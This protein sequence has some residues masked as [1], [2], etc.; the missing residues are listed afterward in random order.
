MQVNVYGFL[1]VVGVFL[2]V[3]VNSELVCR[4]IGNWFTARS[5]GLRKAKEEYERLSGVDS[6]REQALAGGGR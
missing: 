2:T 4:E 3:I 1:I 6:T 5:I